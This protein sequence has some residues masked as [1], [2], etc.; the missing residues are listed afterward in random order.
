VV[1][2]TEMVSGRES[3]AADVIGRWLRPMGFND[4]A[5]IAGGDRQSRGF[6]HRTKKRSG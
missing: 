1:D 3:F 4:F 2:V 6:H 5:A